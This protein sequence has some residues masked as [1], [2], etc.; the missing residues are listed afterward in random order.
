MSQI[1]ESKQFMLHPYGRPCRNGKRETECVRP[2][3]SG[4][5]LKKF[6]YHR[7]QDIDFPAIPQREA[8]AREVFSFSW[9]MNIVT[10]EHHDVP[11]WE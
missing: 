5:N 7:L 2:T 4:Q 1:S 8:P 6:T 10:R 3:G 11:T 9:Q